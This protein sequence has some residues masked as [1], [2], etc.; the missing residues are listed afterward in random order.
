MHVADEAPPV[1]RLRKPAIA[2]QIVPHRQ[3]EH[4]LANLAIE[5]DPEVERNLRID[6]VAAEARFVIEHREPRGLSLLADAPVAKAGH[7]RIAELRQA[8]RD[9]ILG[10]GLLK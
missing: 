10:G 5:R 7:D 1:R 4:E 3:L 8:L 9:A 6:H 2:D